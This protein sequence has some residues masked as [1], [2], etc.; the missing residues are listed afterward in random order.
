MLDLPTRR[1]TIKLARRLAPHHAPSDLILLEG[2][3]GAGKTF[4]ARA[5]C[6]AL[7]VP[8]EIR[9]QS[10]TFTLEQRLEMLR[11]STKHL[12]GVQI[13]SFG[14]QYLIDY[15]KETGATHILRGVRSPGD[16]DYERVMRNINGDLDP[17]ITT[18]FL[19]PPRD[20]AEV[21]SSMVRGLIGPKG[22]KPVVRKYVPAPVYSRLLEAFD[23]RGQRK[24][25]A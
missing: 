11:A 14:N 2:D 23:G 19:M 15:A 1:S 9:V 22:W 8:P 18:V 24:T 17:N 7:G 5:L 10:P 16:Y 13:A 12:K 3:L 21:S 25:V 6:R 20:I 4:F